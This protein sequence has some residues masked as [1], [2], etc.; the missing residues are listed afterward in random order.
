MIDIWETDYCLRFNFAASYLK[1]YN[2]TGPLAD[3]LS[4]AYGTRDLKAW[5]RKR[6]V[7]LLDKCEALRDG[8]DLSTAVQCV[9]Q[10]SVVA[11]AGFGTEQLS[12]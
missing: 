3:F 11:L 8:R 4:I 6:I 10:A 7:D 9:V 5:A 2:A 1:E 12:L